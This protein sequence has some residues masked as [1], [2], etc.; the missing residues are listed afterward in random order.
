M[1]FD[2]KTALIVL[3]AVALGYAL[4][5]AMPVVQAEVG[6]PVVVMPSTSRAEGGNGILIIEKIIVGKITGQEVEA[7]TLRFTDSFQCW[8]NYDDL[9]CNGTINSTG[10][11]A[12][13]FFASA[14]GVIC[15]D[16]GHIS[17]ASI[18]SDSRLSL[19][20][21]IEAPAK[22]VNYA[23]IYI[24]SADGELKVVFSNG[25]IRTITTD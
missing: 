9:V 4:C 19:K 21:G 20:D 12:D 25:T 22:T 7:G 24:D 16:L 3:A 8:G 17:G 2:L 11:A 14:Y 18:S 10:L 13:A 23:Q 15:N 1:R 6:D 5:L